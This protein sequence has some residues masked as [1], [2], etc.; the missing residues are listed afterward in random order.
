MATLVADKREVTYIL[1][2]LPS[3]SS[4]SHRLRSHPQLLPSGHAMQPSQATDDRIQP[5]SLAA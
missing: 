2:V 1:K 4:L 5:K 3:H